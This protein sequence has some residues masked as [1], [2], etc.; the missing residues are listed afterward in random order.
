MKP[1]TIQEIA[2]ALGKET[3]S[4]AIV[5]GVAVDTRLTRPGDLFFALPSLMQGKSADSDWPAD[6]QKE[7]KNEEEIKTTC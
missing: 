7:K 1:T 5:K 6:S 4:K 2:C 3:K